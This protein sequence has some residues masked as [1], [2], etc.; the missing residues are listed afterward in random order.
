MA[1]PP[2]LCACF[3]A[4]HSPRL[5]CWAPPLLPFPHLQLLSHSELQPSSACLALSHSRDHM[6]LISVPPAA[7]GTILGTTDI[8]VVS[9]KIESP[10][11][12]YHCPHLP[13]HVEVHAAAKT[14]VKC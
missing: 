13:L 2:S 4:R 1:P 8:N 6:A 14:Q 5:L 9:T 7:S 12:I 10:F 11:P 3:P